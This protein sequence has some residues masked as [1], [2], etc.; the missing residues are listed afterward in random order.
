MLGK[1]PQERGKRVSIE[2]SL[3]GELALLREHLAEAQLAQIAHQRRAIILLEGPDGSGKKAALKQLAGAFDPCHFIVQGVSHDRRQAAEGHWLARFWRQLPTA[4]QTVFFYRSWYLRI[5]DDRLQG[6]IDDKSL[7]RSFDEINEF[8]AQQRDYGTMIIKLYF[9]VPADIQIERL[10]VR[11]AR[12]W[13][14]ASAVPGFAVNHP[15][16]TQALEDLRDNSDT[17][18]SPWTIIDG[19][20]EMRAAKDAL[21][22]VLAAYRSTM[23]AEP[24]Q[25][26]EN[27]NRAA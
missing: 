6:R 12:P 16:Y 21:T 26:V 24:P 11:A 3:E 14:S 22:A 8:E 10:A 27:G 15:G 2:A 7:A 4:G 18:W 1:K 19:S 9:D 17:R 23:P 5:L 13:R 25:I 20:D